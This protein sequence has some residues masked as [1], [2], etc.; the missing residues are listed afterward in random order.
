[1]VNKTAAKMSPFTE[2][3]YFYGANI[4]GKPRRYLLNSLGRPKMRELMEVVVKSDFA[5]F[6]PTDRH[7][8]SAERQGRQAADDA[9]PTPPSGRITSSARS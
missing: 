9:T 3:S 6:F 5:G 4:P 8:R 1:M 2:P 7:T